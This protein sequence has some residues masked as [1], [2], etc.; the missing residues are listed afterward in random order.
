M[1]ER[2]RPFRAEAYRTDLPI[3]VR[4]PAAGFLHAEKQLGLNLFIP[5]SHA[6]GFL[7]AAI[8]PN[9]PARLN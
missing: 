4:E 7:K 3:R 8:S 1:G 6:F 5:I 2:V 9:D